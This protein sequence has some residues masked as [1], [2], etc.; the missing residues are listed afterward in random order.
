MLG[1]QEWVNVGMVLK[2]EGYTAPDWDQWSQQDSGRYHSGECFKKWDSFEG[3]INQ[4][5]VQRLH[6]WQKI[7]A[8]HPLLEMRRWPI[9]LNGTRKKMIWSL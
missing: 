1:Y 7:M 6:S 8:G 5:L 4:S 2:H 3:P 9:G